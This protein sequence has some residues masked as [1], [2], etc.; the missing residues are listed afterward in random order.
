MYEVW[1][2]GAKKLEGS[3]MAAQSLLFTSIQIM[4]DK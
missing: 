3:V 4:T 2:E 1:R